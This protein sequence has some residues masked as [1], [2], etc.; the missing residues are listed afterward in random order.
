MAKGLLAGMAGAAAYNV[1]KESDGV[2]TSKD[3]ASGLY[4]AFQKRGQAGLGEMNRMQKNIDELQSALLKSLHDKQQPTVIYAGGGRSGW[5]TTAGFVVIIGGVAV[6]LRFVKGWSLGDFMYVTKASLQNFKDSM[7]EG[8]TKLNEQLRE[9]TEDLID[10]L[11]NVTSKQDDMLEQQAAMDE[12]LR[13]VG[14][15]V[16]GV[17]HNVQLLQDQVGYSNQAITLLCGALSEVAKRCGI[18]NGRYVHA[19][20]NLTRSVH[21]EGLDGPLLHGQIEGLAEHAPAAAAAGAPR[22]NPAVFTLPGTPILPTATTSTSAGNSN[23]NSPRPT[24]TGYQR[25]Q[26][27]GPER[28]TTSEFSAHLHH[29][30]ARASTAAGGVPPAAPAAT[31]TSTWWGGANKKKT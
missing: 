18:S 1:Y 8:V 3:I 22:P 14:D 27:M 23:A 29:P 19:L 17:H 11:R 26:S 5:S 15:D 21:I 13:L 31:T 7:Q 9:A 12:Q 4:D 30:M 16:H 10:K 6:Y 24:Q 2:F 28:A 20:D 25:A